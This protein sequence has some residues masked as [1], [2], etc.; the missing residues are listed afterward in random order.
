M[1]TRRLLWI[2]AALLLF[3]GAVLGYSPRLARHVPCLDR[4]AAGLF[5]LGW[6]VGAAATLSD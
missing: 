5:V 3:A 4:V 1:S 6:A 2:L